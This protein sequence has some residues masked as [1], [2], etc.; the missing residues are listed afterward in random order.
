MVSW[1]GDGVVWEEG[2]GEWELRVQ[3]SA[4][5]DIACSFEAN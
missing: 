3:S 5:C 1:D 2:E 4:N